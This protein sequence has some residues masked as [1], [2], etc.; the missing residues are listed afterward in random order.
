MALSAFD[1][2]S[3]P[4][5]DSDLAEVLGGVMEL[6]EKL[7]KEIS[8]RFDPVVEDWTFS[9]KK[10]G[11]ALR[12]K[13]KKRAVLYMTPSENIFHV[14][15]ALGEKAVVAAH[16]RGLPKPLLEIIDSSQKYAEGRGVR[17]E[18]R[19]ENAVDWALDLAEVKMEN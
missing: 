7:R 6:W 2:K 17:I 3:R 15:F 14:G 8:L 4:P 12:L 19:T 10:W 16:R 9:G 11:W 1:D 13:R 5:T 18:V